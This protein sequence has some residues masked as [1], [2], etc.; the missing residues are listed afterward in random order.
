MKTT[1]G[2]SAIRAKLEQ[3]GLLLPSY[4]ANSSPIHEINLWDIKIKSILYFQANY[5]LLPNFDL[6]D[7]S[8]KKLKPSKIYDGRYN[9]RDRRWRIQCEAWFHELLSVSLGYGCIP[10]IDKNINSVKS[11]EEIKENFLD[12]C[13][14]KTLPMPY[15]F[16]YTSKEEQIQFF[17]VGD[18]KPFSPVN[19][20]RCR[21]MLV[22]AAKEYKFRDDPIPIMKAMELTLARPR[23]KFPSL[24]DLQKGIFVSIAPLVYVEGIERKSP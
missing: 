9:V 12:L 20:E 22:K 3:F 18:L 4:L 16:S 1:E 2:K 8:W 17:D 19:I 6:V 5:Q 23:E 15:F 21:N 13:F 24:K 7:Y 11:I 10:P 14:F